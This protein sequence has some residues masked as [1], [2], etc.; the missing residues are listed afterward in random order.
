MTTQYTVIK[1]VPDPV[2]NES[3]NIGLLA[4]SN[5]ES[6]VHFLTDWR[7]ARALG[8][9]S[10]GYLPE[11]ARE[12]QQRQEELFSTGKVWT[13]DALKT[14]CEKWR[15]VVQFEPP[16]ASLRALDALFPQLIRLYLK[17]GSVRAKAP[18]R[19]TAASAVYVAVTSALQRRYGQPGAGL[20]K[21]GF[22][23]RGKLDSHPYDVAIVNG[24]TYG[25]ALGMSFAS[26]SS[27]TI[28]REIDALAFAVEDV[29]SIQSNVP[30]AVAYVADGDRENVRRASRIFRALNATFLPHDRVTSWAQS[31]AKG[32]PR[33]ALG[34]A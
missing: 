22:E 18:S 17:E 28:R 4:M 31:A 7:R 13:V 3:I 33:E 9:K 21:R 30:I 12:F 5:D 8:P 27:A 14:Y 15:H 23:L 20:V 32:V 25:A 29:R 26:G 11:F 1:F 24:A 16:R 19:R 34:N 10:A 2:A 6:R